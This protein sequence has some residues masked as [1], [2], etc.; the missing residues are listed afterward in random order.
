MTTTEFNEME[1]K[2]VTSQVARKVANAE[3]SVASAQVSQAE[4]KVLQ[5]RIISPVDGTIVR[6]LHKR[7]EFA[8]AGIPAVIVKEQAGNSR[9]KKNQGPEP[10]R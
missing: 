6:V 4:L 5:H 10:G 2:L 8:K 1:Q 7:G 9:E 3:M